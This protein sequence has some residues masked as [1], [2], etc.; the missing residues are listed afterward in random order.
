[1]KLNEFILMMI[2]HLRNAF[3]VSGSIGDYAIDD[4]SILLYEDYLVGEWIAIVGSR[5][6]D[7]IYR[8]DE[9]IPTTP[10]TGKYK[11]RLG[12][13]TDAESPVT[14]EAFTGTVWSLKLPRS[15]VTLCGEIKAWMDSPAGKPTNITSESVVGFYSKTMATSENGMP[16][17][18]EDVFKSRIHDGWREMFSSELVSSL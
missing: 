5:V 9:S 14:D 18:W 13:G 1:M 16:V 15:L 6:N 7:G 2:R 12:N 10:L 3:E 11:Y 4:G 17:G 8:I